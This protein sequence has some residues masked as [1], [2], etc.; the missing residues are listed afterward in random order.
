MIYSMFESNEKHILKVLELIDNSYLDKPSVTIKG[1]GYIY[2]RDRNTQT[3]VAKK[4]YTVTLKVYG[5]LMN[6]VLNEINIG[7]HIMVIGHTEMAKSSAGFFNRVTVPEQIYKCDWM[8][9]FVQP[10]DGN[11]TSWK[12]WSL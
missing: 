3:G 1:K 5:Y 10:L 6:Y 9:Y 12:D 4:P 11:G 7:D 8:H 2:I